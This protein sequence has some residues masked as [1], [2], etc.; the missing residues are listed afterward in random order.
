MA[1]KKKAKKVK[2]YVDNA[3]VHVQ[4]SFNN[5]MVAITTTEGDVLL[6]G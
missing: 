4:S 1:Y 6:R 3:I 2:R 5:T